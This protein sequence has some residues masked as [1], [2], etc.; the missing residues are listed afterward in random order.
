MPPHDV[1]NQFQLPPVLN[2]PPFT[3][4]VDMLPE[5]IDCG[6][7]AADVAGEELPITVIVTDVLLLTHCSALHDNIT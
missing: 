3:L 5:H 7:L 1:L 4:K 2:V 6:L